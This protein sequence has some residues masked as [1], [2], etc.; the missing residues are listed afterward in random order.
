[1]KHFDSS[2]FH[3]NAQINRADLE[4]ELSVNPSNIAFYIEQVAIW[5]GEA[6]RLKLLRDNR[7]AEIYVDLK[8]SGNKVTDGY[9][10]ATQQ[11]DDKYKGYSEALRIAREQQALYE[12]AVEALSKKQFSLGSLSANNRL[13]FD[14][15]T[16]VIPRSTLEEK[17]DRKARIVAAQR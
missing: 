9:I 17:A 10:S 11:L 15:T 3:A 4:Q 13:E 2:K 7:A 6:D 16:S 12:G 8:D 5:T 14:A 1:M